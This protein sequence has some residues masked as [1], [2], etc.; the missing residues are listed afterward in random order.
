RLAASFNED[1]IL[2][3]SPDLVGPSIT[4]NSGII[5]EG[6]DMNLAHLADIRTSTLVFNLTHRLLYTKFR[7][8]GEEPKLFLFGQLKRIVKEWLDG[9]L[10][11]VGDTYPAQLM[12]LEL[13]DMACNKITAA[14]TQ[15]FLNERPVKALLDPYNPSGST[16]SVRFNTSKTNLWETSSKHCHLNWIVLDSE[17]EGEFCRVAES[18]PKVLTY[19]KNHNI[20]FEVPYRYG[21]ETRRYLPDFIVLV[22]DGHGMEDP[23]HLIVEIKGYR[24]EDAKEK[25]STM[26]TYWIP[27]VNNLRTFGRWAFAEFTEVYQIESDFKERIDSEFEKMIESSIG[28]TIRN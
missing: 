23:L 2:R 11:C 22:D 18:H 3:L 24:R 8:P 7:D 4:R 19:V 27:G 1:S 5:G 26:D 28:K 12:Y 21:S 14:I 13:A 17:W 10:V 6:V 9:Y 25:K 16:R 20:G 15:K